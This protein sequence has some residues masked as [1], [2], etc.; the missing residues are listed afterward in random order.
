M[1]VAAVKRKFFSTLRGRLL[2]LVVL[3]LLPAFVL[4]IYKDVEDGQQ[5]AADARRAAAQVLRFSSQAQQ[6]MLDEAHNLL[7]F[8][9]MMPGVLLD[10]PLCQK[11]MAGLA[12]EYA[13]FGSFLVL[14]SR[15]DVVCSKLPGFAGV[16]YADRTWFKEAI[17]SRRF[18][19]GEYLVGRVTGKPMV[20]FSAPV[21]D[22]DIVK[23]VVSAAVF[24]EWFNRASD[25]A[26]LPAG[27]TFTIFDRHGVV[28]AQ[29]PDADKWVGKPYPVGDV[30]QTVLASS[31]EGFV[32]S[33]GSDGMSRLFAFKPLVAPNAVVYGYL[34][35]GIPKDTA[36]RSAHAMFLFNVTFVSLAALLVLAI[37][38][39]GSEVLVLKPI[40][41]LAD[42]SA[43]LSKGDLTARSGVTARP[44]EIG[45]LALAFDHMAASLQAR[46]AESKTAEEMRARLAAIVESSSDA[47]IGR[48]LE[49]R[50]TSWNKGAERLFGYRAEEMIGRETR[51]LVPPDQIE[52]AKEHYIRI[53]RGERIES[54]E[55]TRVKKGGARIHV[56]VTVSPVVDDAGE[57]IGASSIVRDIGDRIR[58]ESELRALHEINLALTSSL[59]LRRI[60]DLL[61]ERIE[62]LL[63]CGAAHIR[64]LDKATGQLEPVTCRNLDEEQWKAG[65]VALSQSVH[66]RILQTQRPVII[67]NLDRDENVRRRDFYRREGLV[68]FLGLPLT[69]QEEAIGVLSLFTREEHEFSPKEIRFAE[70]L[71]KQ[72][73]VAIHNAQLYQESR[74]L[75]E[76]LAAREERIRNLVAR[77][78]HARDEEA[79]RIASA[80]HDESRQF[81]ALVYI[82]LDELA[83]DLAEAEQNRVLRIKGL[84]DQVEDRLRDLSY[85]LYP[86]MLDQLGLVPSLEF[87]AHQTAKRLGIEIVVK[88]GLDRRLPQRL[89]LAIYRVVQ[90][91]LNNIA[92]HAGAKSALIRVQQDER[93][94]QCAVQDDGVGFDP[95]AVE[96]RHGLGLARM[97]ERVHA[98]GGALEL[99]SAPGQGT[100]LFFS[101]RQE[102][103]DDSPSAFS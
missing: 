3:S 57:V 70:T 42:A 76:Q 44:D 45:Q 50:I 102:Q 53:N 55:T 71:A 5:A 12:S 24:L 51:L 6:Q 33:A 31:G 46:E 88:G 89:E 16:N 93:W 99:I 63:P 65:R 90:E 18:A 35:V 23:G 61:L 74:K 40:R 1:S 59:D 21:L 67:R 37:G 66:A 9:S 97:R 83:R 43:R 11:L 39:W 69:A 47:I 25:L 2:V 30:L 81:L 28:L 75:S 73:S 101:L 13:K 22:G 29:E 36:Y 19:A 95:A 96:Q 56:S 79:K 77:L 34:L 10:P 91:A 78:I 48:D 52:R 82:S 27:S 32:E 94:I 87:L 68:S 72:A 86:A 85:E 64:L 15:G 58:S 84:L 7:S 60:L 20:A 14:D 4:I 26:R 100:Q 103:S 62:I 17:Q 8:L 80:L 92:R 54:F 98:A 41:A 38:R 49:G